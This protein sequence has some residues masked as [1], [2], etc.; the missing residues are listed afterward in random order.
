MGFTAKVVLPSGREDTLY[1]RINHIVESNH[2]QSISY[3]VRGFLS[4]DDYK[5]GKRFEYELHNNLPFNLYNLNQPLREQC[6]NH[7]KLNH[8]VIEDIVAD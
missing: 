5:S 2:G 8:T 6:Y 3:C 1:M 4:R 7:E